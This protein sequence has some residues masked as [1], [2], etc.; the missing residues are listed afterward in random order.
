MWPKFIS[1]TQHYI[2]VEFVGSLL[3]SSRFLKDPSASFN[4]NSNDDELY[5]SIKF[6][7]NVA[8]HLGG[9]GGNQ[10]NY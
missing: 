9:G 3:C 6:S 5:L 7:S 4:N 2:R 8:L 10:V 1:Q